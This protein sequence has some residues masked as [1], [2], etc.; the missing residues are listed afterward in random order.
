MAAIGAPDFPAFLIDVTHCRRGERVPRLVSADEARDKLAVHASEPG[1]CQPNAHSHARTRANKHTHTNA[2]LGISGPLTTPTRR[3]PHP[4][5]LGAGRNETTTVPHWASNP[6]PR[7]PGARAASFPS[8]VQPRRRGTSLSSS[9][10]NANFRCFNCPSAALLLSRVPWPRNTAISALVADKFLGFTGTGS[11]PQRPG[12]S[13]SLSL[14]TLHVA[15]AGYVHFGLRHSFH[16]VFR[17]LRDDFDSAGS[18]NALV[19]KGPHQ[20]Q[21]RVRSGGPSPEQRKHRRRCP[22]AMILFHYSSSHSSPDSATS[23]NFL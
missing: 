23:R 10:P 16:S 7:S 14:Q 13:H 3:C 12:P 17:S 1:R 4:P 18:E 21:S 5:L 6:L 11:R 19:G 22:G 9:V 8:C 20:S 15:H 2:H